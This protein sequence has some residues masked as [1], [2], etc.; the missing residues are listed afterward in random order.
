MASAALPP[1]HTD[2]LLTRASR[3]KMS[4]SS[5]DSQY[6]QQCAEC[7]CVLAKDVAIHILTQH[8]TK[9]E[10][11]WCDACWQEGQDEMRAEGWLADGDEDVYAICN[12]GEVINLE[13][14][15]DGL[16]AEYCRGRAE[17]SCCHHCREDWTDC[18]DASCD[19][20][21]AQR[22]LASEFGDD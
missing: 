7:D 17:W 20:C 5:N 16:A 22:D 8:R 10:M 9:K 3:V 6:E 19:Y 13:D 1:H 2:L 14:E 12:C 18:K 15:D 4:Q 21:E 11:V